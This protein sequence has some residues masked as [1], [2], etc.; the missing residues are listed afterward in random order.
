MNSEKKWRHDFYTANNWRCW[1]CGI[2]LLGKGNEL[3]APT[4]DHLLPWSRGGRNGEDNLVAACKSC[5]SR[6]HNMTLEEYRL[7]MSKARRA[8]IL[9]QQAL[10]LYQTPFDDALSNAELWLLEQH[11]VTFYGEQVNSSQM[12]P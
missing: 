5:N 6:K 2:E 7:Y 11:D 12:L 1:F 3:N 10:S 4:V 8:A 9:I